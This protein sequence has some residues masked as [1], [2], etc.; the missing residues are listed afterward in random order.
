MTV[1]LPMV[2]QKLEKHEQEKMKPSV[3][4]PEEKRAEAGSE[5]EK[6]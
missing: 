3:A 4:Q 2:I 6:G 5:R 1:L